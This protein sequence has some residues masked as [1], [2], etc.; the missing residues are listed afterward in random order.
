MTKRLFLSIILV[1]VFSCLAVAGQVFFDPVDGNLKSLPDDIKSRSFS[2]GEIRLGTGYGVRWDAVNDVYVRGVASNGYFIPTTPVSFPIQEQMKRVVLQDNGTVAY[3]LCATDSTY[4]ADCSTASA[5]DG[6]DG[7]VMVQIPKFHYIQIQDGNYRYFLIGE[8]PFTL[9]SSGGAK[10]QSAIFPAFYGG[11]STAS[12]YVYIGAYEA[13]MY[14]DSG[15]AMTSAS[16]IHTSM[17]ETGD[18]ACSVSGQY[19]KTNELRADYRTMATERGTGWHQYGAYDYALVA[20]LYIT[21]HGDF[22]SQGVIGNGRTGL[23]GG[24]WRA[25]EAGAGG[26]IGITGL[27]NGDGN[28]SGNVSVGGSIA[29]GESGD[30]MT[31]RGIENLWGNVW[32]F[33]DGANVHNS[34]ANGSRLY[35]SADYTA[36]DDGTAYGYTLVGTLAE[37]DGYSI[38]I[39]DTIGVWPSDTGGSSSTFLTDHCDTYFDD[40]NDSGWMEVRFGGAALALSE[41]GVFEIFSD[42]NS[43]YK[44]A[45]TGAR[46]CYSH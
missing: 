36:F 45:A 10:N 16:V 28:A 6:T 12:D 38:D 13:T 2:A 39:I 14:D 34:T 21:E 42:I 9:I 20:A 17:Y 7:Q 25:G 46:L 23:S 31:Y 40:D 3:E 4:K 27:S 15:G 29:A 32:Q 33:M 37:A 35:L 5:L 19:P 43:A 8:G 30:Y 22:D 11:S 18:K 41:A 26:Y 24:S 44:S 1:F